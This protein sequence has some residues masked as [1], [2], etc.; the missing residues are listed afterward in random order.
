MSNTLSTPQTFR[1][2]VIDDAVAIHQDI[3]RVLAPP[4]SDS[5][6]AAMEAA[7][8]ADAADEADEPKAMVSTFEIESAYQG[9]EGIE[10][11]RQAKAEGR[12]YALAFVDMRMP[13][14][15]DGRETVRR[16]WQVDPDVQVVVCT[17]YSDYTWEE[18]AA[19]TGPTT[20]VVVLRKPFEPIEVLQLAHT[21]TEK[22]RRDRDARQR[23][24]QLEKEVADRDHELVESRTVAHL[25]IEEAMQGRKRR[26]AR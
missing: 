19:T 8:L 6:L 1:V 25:L 4:R 17:A 23:V 15:I 11:V 9:E 7:I 13:P 3:R 18:I 14:G 2:L 26:R 20:Q 22:W 12:P 10:F 21:L 16:L 24:V 5:K